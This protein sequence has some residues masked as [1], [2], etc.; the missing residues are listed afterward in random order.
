METENDY[1]GN[2][3][4]F[5]DRN[6][7]RFRVT[8]KGGACPPWGPQV[9]RACNHVHGDRYRVNLIKRNP[10]AQV[11][12]DFWNSAADM[13][14]GKQPTAYDVLACISSDIYTPETFEDFCSEYGYDTD[15]RRTEK[16]FERADSFARK[17]REFFSE[18]ET[19]QLSEI[20]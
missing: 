8:W 14:A 20:R 17:L 2:A 10:P 3:Q 18:T 9:D 7:I 13:Q 12:F 4:R 5:L 19:S 1:E 11:S 15:S 16:L 6:G